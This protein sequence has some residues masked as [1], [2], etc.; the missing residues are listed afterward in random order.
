MDFQKIADLKGKI[1]KASIRKKSFRAVQFI[2]KAGMYLLPWRT[3]EIMR[4]AGSS[5]KLPV[6]LSRKNLKKPLIV[7]GMTD[8]KAG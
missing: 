3:P 2:T 8:S 6:G 4:G 1:N 5:R 7:T